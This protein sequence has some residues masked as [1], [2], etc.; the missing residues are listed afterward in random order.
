MGPRPGLG[1]LWER[2]V[3]PERY[4]SQDDRLSSRLLSRGM[5][6]LL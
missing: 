3:G 5:L 2:L 1:C 6:G 4:L